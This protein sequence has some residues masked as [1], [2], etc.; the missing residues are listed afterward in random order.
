[1]RLRE[2]SNKSSGDDEL[3]NQT[4]KVIRRNGKSV[5]WKPN[6]IETAVSQAFLSLQLDPSPASD[7]ANGISERISED[8]V[9]FFHIEDLQD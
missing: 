6:K 7:V 2:D 4:I 8:G 5:S 1:M 9:S 3:K